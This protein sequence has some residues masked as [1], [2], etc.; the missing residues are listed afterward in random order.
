MAELISK[1][2]SAIDDTTR[3]IAAKECEELVMKLWS[4]RNSLPSGGPFSSIMP[5]LKRLL[6]ERDLYYRVPFGKDPDEGGLISQII[7]LHEREMLIFLEA[8]NIAISQEIFE[9][10]QQIREHFFDELDEY[11]RN[12]LLFVARNKSH[13]NIETEHDTEQPSDNNSGD[14]LNKTNDSFERIASD[15]EEIIRK[16]FGEILTEGDPS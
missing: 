2:E 6:G 1:T 10:S 13:V 9:A 3:E 5:T 12:V 15:R 4:I 7:R 8:P 14:I 16:A 11:E